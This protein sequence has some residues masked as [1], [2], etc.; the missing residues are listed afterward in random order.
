MRAVGDDNPLLMCKNLTTFV[1]HVALGCE[2]SSDAIDV[3]RRS[4]DDFFAAFLY[5]LVTDKV[6]VDV[7]TKKRPADR[8]EFWIDKDD[9]NSTAHRVQEFRFL[10]EECNAEY[11][12]SYYS[13]VPLRKKKLRLHKAFTKTAIVNGGGEGEGEDSELGNG[14]T[15]GSTNTVL[16]NR[17][18]AAPADDP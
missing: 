1:N 15:R 3:V 9:I 7:Q 5:E 16:L 10:S 2:L 4:C 6:C 18:L 13:A 14:Q 8:K 17:W 11:Q 12:G